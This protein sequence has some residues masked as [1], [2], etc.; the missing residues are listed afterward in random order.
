MNIQFIIESN[1]RI[2][3][4]ALK[5]NI[6]AGEEVFDVITNSEWKTHLTNILNGARNL[7]EIADLSILQIPELDSD[8]IETVKEYNPDNII[9]E[10]QFLSI[11]YGKG[12]VR[13]YVTEDFARSTS[14]EHIKLPGGRIVEIHCNN[15]SSNNFIDLVEKIEESRIKRCWLETSYNYDKRT[16]NLDV[17]L[18]EWI[19]K[20]GTEV[21]ITCKDNGSG[22]PIVG[23]LALKQGQYDESI[24]LFIT[25]KKER[26]FEETQEIIE[27]LIPMYIK[28]NTS[29]PREEPW[30][31]N[32]SNSIF[33]SN[34]YLTELGQ[35][36]EDRFN[37]LINE[38]NN[39][40]TINNI[41]EK[42]NEITQNIIQIRN[43]IEFGKKGIEIQEFN[44][45]TEILRDF[46]NASKCYKK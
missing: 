42:I 30:Y 19:P 7:S 29:I 14:L 4:E 2:Q 11:E 31:E 44:S 32:K 25:D 45:S 20:V 34:W 1:Y 33:F 17:V 16:T 46:F 39:G 28:E 27:R 36:L 12:Y 18:L 21:Q 43:E 26:I 37:T 41:K 9:I 24:T 40:A 38:Y 8:M 23:F 3:K 13:T 6:Q 10:N 35:K 15:H 5:F 22:E